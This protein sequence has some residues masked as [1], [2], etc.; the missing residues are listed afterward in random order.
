MHTLGE[1]L[2]EYVPNSFKLQKFTEHPHLNR[3][4]EYKVYENRPAQIPMCYTLTA[5]AV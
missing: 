3:G 1:I 5:Q 4:V 2:T